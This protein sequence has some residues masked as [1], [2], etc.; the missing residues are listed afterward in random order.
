VRGE[1]I[2]AAYEDPQRRGVEFT[3][4]PHVW[5]RIPTEPAGEAGLILPVVASR[6]FNWHRLMH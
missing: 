4:A 1:G 6:K 3:D 2:Q 5:G